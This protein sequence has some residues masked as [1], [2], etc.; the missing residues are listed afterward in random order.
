MLRFPS[1]SVLV[2]VPGVAAGPGAGLGA[3]VMLV[4]GAGSGPGAEAGVAT[5]LLSS[6]A[7][8]F[9]SKNTPASNA[10]SS[11]ATSS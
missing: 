1:R 5:P 4:G 6:S 9:L 3:G 2:A 8:A 11:G 10:I 7:V